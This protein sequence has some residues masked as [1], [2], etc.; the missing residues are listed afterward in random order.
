MSRRGSLGAIVSNARKSVV[1]IATSRI[2]DSWTHTYPWTMFIAVAT[3]S[4]MDGLLVGKS[5]NSTE[6]PTAT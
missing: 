4:L 5:H 1:R 6:N 3:D 2:Q